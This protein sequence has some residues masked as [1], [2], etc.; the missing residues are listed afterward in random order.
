FLVLKD[1]EVSDSSLVRL[2]RERLGGA[3]LACGTDWWFVD[4]NRSRP[5][6]EGV[7]ALAYSINGTVHADDDTSLMETPS[8]Q[9]DT[10]RSARA[11]ARP[12][13]VAPRRRLSAL[14]RPRRPRRVE[15]GRARR[16]ALERAA[17]GRG[18]R[19]ARERLPAC[20][21]REPDAGVPAGGARPA[22]RRHRR[23]AP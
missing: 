13:P 8:A 17:G 20:A 1:G 21:R 12:V 2:A 11:A 18:A 10:V 14:P 3:E 9:E 16:G 7:D 23:R 22:G 19:S 4:V 6:L 15:G 5:D